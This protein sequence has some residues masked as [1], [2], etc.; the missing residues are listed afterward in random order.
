LLTETAETAETGFWQAIKNA[1]MPKL[2]KL[3]KLFQHFGIV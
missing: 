2:L 1:K 3:P